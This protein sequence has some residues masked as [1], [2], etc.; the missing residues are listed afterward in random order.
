MP[1]PSTTQ[2]EARPKRRPL[3]EQARSFALWQSPLYPYPQLVSNLTQPPAFARRI[4][5]LRSLGS[6]PVF[7]LPV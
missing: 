7:W 6:A 3:S 1:L 5:A 4:E 2:P